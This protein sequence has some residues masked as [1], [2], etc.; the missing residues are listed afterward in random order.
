MEMSFVHTSTKA[1]RRVFVDLL[2][3]DYEEGKCGLLKKSMYG[4]RDAA[5]DWELYYTEMMQEAGFR[6]GSYSACVFYHEQK[7]TSE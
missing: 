7:K 2:K 6:Q 1:R 3:E 5:Q 4:T